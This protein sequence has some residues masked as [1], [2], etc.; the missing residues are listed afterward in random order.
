MITTV[1]CV[2]A[3]GTGRFVLGLISLFF[4]LLPKSDTALFV[5]FS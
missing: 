4:E 1:I 3:T 2:H 5:F